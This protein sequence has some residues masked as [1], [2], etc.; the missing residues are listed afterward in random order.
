[1]V[2]MGFDNSTNLVGIA[3]KKDGELIHY[4]TIKLKKICGYKADYIDRIL[5]LMRECEDLIAKYQPD[6]IGFEDTVVRK[7]GDDYSKRNILVFKKLTEAL[8][9]LKIVARANKIRFETVLP[10]VW[11]KGRGYPKNRQKQKKMAVDDANKE[12]GLNLKY[13]QDDVAEAILITDYIEKNNIK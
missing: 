4:D 10:P 7:S 6:I 13:S 8:G 1:M 9:G 12:F 3:I 5:Q 2:V 11:R